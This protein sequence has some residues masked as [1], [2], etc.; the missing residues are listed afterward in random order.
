MRKNKKGFIQDFALFGIIMIIFI[1]AIFVGSAVLREF[2]EKYQENSKPELN[3]GRELM[4]STTDRF[5]TLFDNIFM[6][7]FIL[8]AIAIFVSM[9]L[10]DSNPALFFIIIIVF[11]FLLIAL[12]ALNNVYDKLV[13]NPTMASQAATMPLIGFVMTN[14]VTFMLV[15]GFVAIILFFA[16]VKEGV[17]R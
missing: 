7:V 4:Q 12:A 5:G 11:S 16:K 2:N 17:F 1:I 13:E 10:I 3:V 9:F 15:F 8:F 14:W 6:I